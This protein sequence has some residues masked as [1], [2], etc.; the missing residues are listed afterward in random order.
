MFTSDEPMP[1]GSATRSDEDGREPAAGPRLAEA[2]ATRSSLDVKARLDELRRGA[3]GT[4]NLMPVLVDC[5]GAMCTV[6]E[7]ANALRD[8]WGE[9]QE[10]KV[11]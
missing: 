6:G 7:I 3:E 4:V 1:D 10:P 8:V 11:F 5:V 2:K 9:Y